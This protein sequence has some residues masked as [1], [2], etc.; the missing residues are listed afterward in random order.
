MKPHLKHFRTE[1]S[2]IKRV[3]EAYFKYLPQFGITLVN[4][5]EDYDIIAS[6][7]RDWETF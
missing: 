6:A 1:E 5:N 4:D 2:G 7:D 3:I